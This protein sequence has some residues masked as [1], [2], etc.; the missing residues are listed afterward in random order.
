MDEMAKLEG[1]EI[2]IRIPTDVDMDLIFDY[3]YGAEH[4]FYV[5][6]KELFTRQFV[7][8]LNAEDEG[9]DSMIHKMLDKAIETLVND[10]YES[11]GIEGED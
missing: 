8:V 11:I 2:V 5:K 3:I 6:D 10:G 7:D 4:G 9:G 1:K